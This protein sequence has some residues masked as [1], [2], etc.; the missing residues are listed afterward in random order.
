MASKGRKDMI[1]TPATHK[2]PIAV[3]E[4][5]AAELELFKCVQQ[6][7]FPEELHSLTKSASNG[8][9]HV[10]KSSCLRSLPRSRF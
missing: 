7:Y 8:V 9:L 1:A 6:H 10:K 5:R 3:E 2:R 4:I